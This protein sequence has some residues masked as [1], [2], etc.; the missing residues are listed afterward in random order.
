VD[1]DAGLP[2]M[3]PYKLGAVVEEINPIEQ[4]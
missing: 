4:Y 1:A 2:K 3:H